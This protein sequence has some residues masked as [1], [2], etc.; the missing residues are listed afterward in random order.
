MTWLQLL[1]EF[2]MGH[3]LKKQIKPQTLLKN[4]LTLCPYIC[5]LCQ[6]WL[7]DIVFR[8]YFG[9]S[10][11][12]STKSYFIGSTCNSLRRKILSFFFFCLLESKLQKME[13]L[14]LSTCAS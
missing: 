11:R 10:E 4:E 7:K 14:K 12:Q 2:L 5:I 3:G 1:L 9:K 6:K 13:I 8:Y